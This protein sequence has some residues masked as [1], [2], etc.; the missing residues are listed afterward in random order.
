MGSDE[1]GKFC[2]PDCERVFFRFVAGGRSWKGAVL[3]CV[4]ACVRGLVL[5]WGA[6]P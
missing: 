4:V 3:R 1:I 2:I 5:T 6:A